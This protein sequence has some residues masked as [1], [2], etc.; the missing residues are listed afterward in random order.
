[1]ETNQSDLKRSLWW[2]VT[3]E[4]SLGNPSPFFS[5]NRCVEEERKEESFKR[6]VKFTGPYHTGG[7]PFDSEHKSL[8]RR[9]VL[10]VPL[11]VRTRYVTD[12][13]RTST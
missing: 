10:H 2:I 13:C 3:G 6:G 4:T 12:G 11:G 7:D 8:P 1:M 5:L 9:S